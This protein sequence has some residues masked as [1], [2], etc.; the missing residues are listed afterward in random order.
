MPLPL[1]ILCIVLLSLALLILFVLSLKGTFT[2]EYDEELKISFKLLFIKIQ[3]FPIKKRK[4]HRVRSMSRARA[5]R[6]RRSA[7]LK[8]EK[9]RQKRA[10]KK[11]GAGPEKENKSKEGQRITIDTVRDILDLLKLITELSGE[12]VKRFS[13]RLHVKI[14]K[15]KIRVASPD[16]ATTAVAYGAISQIINI[17]LPILSDVKNLKLPRRKNFNV[18][19]DFESFTPSVEVKLSFSLRVWHILDITF[20]VMTKAITYVPEYVEKY[21]SKKRNENVGEQ[22]TQ[23]KSF[24]F[25]D[26]DQLKKLK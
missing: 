1:Q 25:L 5:A 20:P 22:D 21:F 16:A 12:L 13:N 8:L 2:I 9:E 15:L 11:K 18:W 26:I 7:E 3:L 6:I 17:L 10:K 23:E 4:I 24:G 14:S 19:T